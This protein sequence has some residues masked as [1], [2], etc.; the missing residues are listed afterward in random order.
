M[1]EQYIYHGFILTRRGRG[2]WQAE[3]PRAPHWL[4]CAKT[5]EDLK[6]I[7]RKQIQQEQY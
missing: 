4:G 6:R 1:N 2:D 3:D 7:V 5:K